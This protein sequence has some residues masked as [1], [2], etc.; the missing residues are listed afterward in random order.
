MGFIEEEKYLLIWSDLLHFY[1]MHT[2]I[3]STCNIMYLHLC[4]SPTM[5]PISCIVSLATSLYQ[6]ISIFLVIIQGNLLIQPLFS[7]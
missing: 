6:E 3:P 2:L 7:V 4:F 1:Q 5:K